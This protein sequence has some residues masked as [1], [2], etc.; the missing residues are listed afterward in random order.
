MLGVLLH[1]FY[2]QYVYYFQLEEEERK[3]T[4]LLVD[5]AFAMSHKLEDISENAFYSYKLRVGMCH[6]EVIAGV[7]G[8][9]KPQY[10]IWG[11][12]VNIASRMDSN[13]VSTRIQVSQLIRFT[14]TGF[15]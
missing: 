5:F 12:V 3:N 10:D 4:G 14:H 15:I 6:G 9:S 11:D 7:V 2:L 8:A 1:R 13:G